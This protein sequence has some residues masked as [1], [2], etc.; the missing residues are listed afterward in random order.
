LPN[1][2]KAKIKIRH[3][4]GLKR[5]AGLELERGEEERRSHIPTRTINC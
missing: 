2:G 1:G 3:K 5:N 4:G